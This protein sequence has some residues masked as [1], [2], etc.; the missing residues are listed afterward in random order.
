MPASRSSSHREAAA[1]WGGR[2]RRAHRRCRRHRRHNDEEPEEGRYA[3][4]VGKHEQ[5]ER[6][7]NREAAMSDIDDSHHAVHE[8]E[9][10][11][12][13]GIIASK[14]H[15]LDDL[16]ERI[17][18]TLPEIGDELWTRYRAAIGSAGQ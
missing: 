16:V 15:A 5:T 8:G 2:H 3:E 12:D 11:G 4:A 7:K 9:S 14:Q 6:R 10:A 13:Q 1:A 18:D 17:A